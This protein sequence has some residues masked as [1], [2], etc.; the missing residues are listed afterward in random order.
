MPKQWRI[1]FD[2]QHQPGQSGRR[3]GARAPVRVLH[4]TGVQTCG[5]LSVPTFLLWKVII[6]TPIRD[7]N[8]LT[9]YME[10]LQLLYTLDQGQR[11]A[12]SLVVDLNL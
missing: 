9:D 10:W 5:R 1:N 7:L 3:A 2:I 8:W 4:G 12:H 11:H 6:P